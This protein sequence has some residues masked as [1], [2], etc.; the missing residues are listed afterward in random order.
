MYWQILG[1]VALDLNMENI[2][3]GKCFKYTADTKEL[4]FVSEQVNSVHSL[5][6]D[7]KLLPITP[8]PTPTPFYISKCSMT[9]VCRKP[10]AIKVL[11]VTVSMATPNTRPSAYSVFQHTTIYTI[12]VESL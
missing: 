9:S 10:C 6:A 12:P 11:K 7:C 3:C 5:T 2:D 8:T 4:I 1:E